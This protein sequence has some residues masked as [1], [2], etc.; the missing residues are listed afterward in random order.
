MHG[1]RLLIATNVSH[2]ACSVA[3][4]PTINLFDGRH[5]IIAVRRER[6]PISSG[7]PPELRVALPP[8]ASVRAALRYIEGDVY[9]NGSCK[10]SSTLELTLARGMHSAAVPFPVTLCGTAAGPVVTA[11]AFAPAP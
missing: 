7:A 10:R 1:E 9:P 4:Y 6:R 8:R 5:R 3:A 11:D 2:R